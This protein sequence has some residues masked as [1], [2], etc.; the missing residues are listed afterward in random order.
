MPSEIYQIIIKKEDRLPEELLNL[1]QE[2]MAELLQSAILQARK[3][4][5]IWS[6]RI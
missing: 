5:L 6:F 1:T 2:E 3:K 4:L